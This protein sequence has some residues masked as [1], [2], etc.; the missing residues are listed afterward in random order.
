M[1]LKI[2]SPSKAIIEDA[3]RDELA[4][5]YAD[6]TYDNTA[7]KHLVKRHYGNHWFK[8]KDKEAW[9][10]KLKELKA[11]VRKTVMFKEDGQLFIRPGSIPH[12]TNYNL[13]IENHIK[14]PIPKK[15][16]WDKPLPFEL[17]PYQ[18]ESWQK[19]VK[20]A[21]NGP[22]NAELCTGS[23]KSAILLKIC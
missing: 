1:K 13:Q 6:L 11:N 12:L 20:E 7:N 21:I 16:P 22:T 10:I 19:L 18:E 15:V 5:L 3:S 14:Y 8:S 4:R 23:G 9:D 17:H 2:V